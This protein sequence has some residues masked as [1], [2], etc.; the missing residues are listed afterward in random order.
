MTFP[1]LVLSAVASHYGN[2]PYGFGA[3]R[4]AQDPRDEMEQRAPRRLQ[5][6]MGAE[7][8]SGGVLT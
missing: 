8:A 1:A 2:D 5:D 4:Y 6:I 7:P 3:P